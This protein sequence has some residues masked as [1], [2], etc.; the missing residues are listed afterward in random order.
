MKLMMAANEEKAAEEAKKAAE[1][2]AQLA[3][4]KAS[5]EHWKNSALASPADLPG[6]PGLV[7]GTWEPM[8]ATPARPTTTVVEVDGLN[9]AL[10]L[11]PSWAYS[12]NQAEMAPNPKTALSN[13]MCGPNYLSLIHI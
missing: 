4:A 7:A 6:A 12:I 10:R 9:D 2:Q 1:L 8:L 5:D 13:T 11:D 3:A